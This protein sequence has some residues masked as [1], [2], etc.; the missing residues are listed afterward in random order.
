[1]R[2]PEL[3]LGGINGKSLDVWS[4]GCLIF[5]FITGQPLFCVPGYSNADKEDDDHLLQLS[6]ILGPLPDH[7]Y[8]LWTRSSNYFAAD[9]IQFNSFLSGVPEGTDLLSAKEEPLNNSLTALSQR[10]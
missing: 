10:L 9:R 3:I 8:Q 1:L 6:D 7:L 5:E 2:P 4:F